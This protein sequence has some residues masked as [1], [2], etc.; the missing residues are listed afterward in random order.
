[1]HLWD[2]FTGKL[3][4]TYKSLNAVVSVQT[5]MR[6]KHK[7]YLTYMY[8]GFLLLFCFEGFF[9]SIKAGGVPF[10]SLK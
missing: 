4:A 10:A 7:T 3:R 8:E 1:M 9:C 5:E 2:A 6:M